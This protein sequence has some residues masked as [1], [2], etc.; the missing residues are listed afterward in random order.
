MA[1]EKWYYAAPYNQGASFLLIEGRHFDDYEN[2][3][4]DR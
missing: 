2:N 1:N 3:F 4:I